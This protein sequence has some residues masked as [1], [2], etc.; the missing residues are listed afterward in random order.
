ME[1]VKVVIYRFKRWRYLP[2]R[3]WQRLS[4]IKTISIREVG[5]ALAFRNKYSPGIEL[6]AIRK[7]SSGLME[8]KYWSLLS[9]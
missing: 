6:V 8:S 1:Q 9:N 5:V 7:Q 2:T 3:Q 4:T